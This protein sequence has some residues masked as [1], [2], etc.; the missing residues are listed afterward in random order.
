[1]RRATSIQR[2]LPSPDLAG[3]TVRWGDLYAPRSAPKLFL[4]ELL[5]HLNPL[6][7][8]PRTTL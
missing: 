1:M 3:Y 8:W 6:Y 2:H 4:F 7:H 5:S